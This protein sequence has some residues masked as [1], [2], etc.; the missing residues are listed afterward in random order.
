MKVHGKDGIVKVGD[1]AVTMAEVGSWNM[2]DDAETSSGWSKGDVN[3]TNETTVKT[4]TGSIELLFDPTDTAGQGAAV[5]GA[6]LD[7]ELYPGTQEAGAVYYGGK[8][9]ITSVGISSPKGEYV[10]KTVGFVNSDGAGITPQTVAA[11]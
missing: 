4:Q 9:K 3:T 10:S 7:V 5:P 11:P 8:A 6:E 2:D 1:P